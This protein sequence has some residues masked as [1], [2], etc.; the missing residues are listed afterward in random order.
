MPKKLYR[1]IALIVIGLLFI[2]AKVINA[3]TGTA[4]NVGAT[5]TAGIGSVSRCSF[6]LVVYGGEPEGVMAAVA[7]ARQGVRTLLIMERETPGGLMTYGGLNYLDINY[8]P[9]GRNLNRGLFSEWHYRV[10]GGISFSIGK[11]TRVFQ[12]MLAAEEHLQ[13]YN[14]SRLLGV[15]LNKG[16]IT[17]IV[18]ERGDKVQVLKVDRVID[19]SQDADLAVKAGVPY[20]KGGADIGLPD[21]HMAVT[22]ILHMGNID[23]NSLKKDVVSPKFGPS[24]INRDHAWGFVKIG[25]LYQPQDQNIKLR[26]LNIVIE[27]VNNRAEVYINSM[28]I[29]NVNPTDRDSLAEAYRRGQQEAEHI[30]EFLQDNLG[31]FK[32][33]VL[34]ESPAELY[35]R[36]GRHILAE[37]QLRVEDLLANRIF[38]DTVALASYPL[39]YQ[40]STPEYDGFVLFNPEVY[41]IPLRSLIPKRINNLLVVGRSSGYSSLAAA[42]A[43]VLPTG[44]TTGEAAGIA[45]AISLAR[46]IELREIPARAELIKQIQSELKIKKA[47]DYF[48]A[49]DNRGLI[50]DEILLPYLEELLSWGLVIAG[51][52]NDFRLEEGISGREFAHL[53]VKG[54]KRREAPIL[55]EWVPGG[56]ETMSS[57]K[58]LSRN[59][60]AL[61][62]L[63]AVSKR[64]S[65]MS[66]DEYYP[67]AVELGLIPSF[68]QET[69]RSDR[70]LSRKEAYII[71]GDFLKKYPLPARL[72]NIRGE[73]DGGDL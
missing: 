14:N 15:N 50:N 26:G 16:K 61:L 24:F 8:G 46:G 10:G 23:W 66:P 33:A 56:L 68:I 62:L 25:R 21:R 9:D 27:E 12:E 58:P 44:M 59:Q 53:I 39:D 29:F 64:V 47:V 49:R 11:A 40:A 70:L 28:L 43:R 19:A 18:I 35:V 55:Y 37:Y 20:F 71:I 17:E 60:A 65:E 5:D 73:N 48:L 1:V 72:R 67:R 38:A 30:L 31:G 34:L 41:G 36:E 13:V 45:A 2:N 42:S 57:E 63:V 51:Y 69:V 22:L 3:N 7:A 32:E 6:P 54:L 52:K 4:G